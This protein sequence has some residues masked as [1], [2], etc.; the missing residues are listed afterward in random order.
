M[1]KEIANLKSET[2]ALR[3]TLSEY[4]SHDKT[5]FADATRRS[6]SNQPLYVSIREAREESKRQEFVAKE[7]EKRKAKEQNICI[8]GLAESDDDN[9]LVKEI[10][11]ELG[12]SP[13]L[14]ETRRLD[15]KRKDKDDAVF[16]RGPRHIVKSETVK[17]KLEI[18]RSASKLRSLEKFRNVYINRDL[19]ALEAKKLF[20]MR[21]ECKAR[22]DKI[23]SDDDKWII[24]RGSPSQ[25]SRLP[26]LRR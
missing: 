17:K 5:S 25:R 20:E 21:K 11:D 19:T 15:V 26:A 4:S 9:A 7:N 2:G 14:V 18:L 23:S 10:C 22:N 13:R 24:F 12:V 6:L 16:H 8:G 3:Q 1:A